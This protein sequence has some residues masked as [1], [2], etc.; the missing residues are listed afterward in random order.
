MLEQ[1]MFDYSPLTLETWEK[2]DTSLDSLGWCV[3]KHRPRGNIDENGHMVSDPDEII[4]G[5]YVD[6]I[7]FQPWWPVCDR[8][9]AENPGAN[10]WLRTYEA[11]FFNDG[12]GHGTQIDTSKPIN[13]RGSSSGGNLKAFILATQTENE[14]EILAFDYLHPEYADGRDFSTDPHL[15][16]YPTA[17]NIA[18]QISRVANG[19]DV[20]V[21]Q[22][23][24][25][26]G[27]WIKKTEVTM[28]DQKPSIWT[29]EDV[30]KQW[31]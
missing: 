24:H 15:F 9:N 26:S 18:G 17:I 8:I 7:P 13:I 10:E 29:K 6:M 4:F 22:I 3:L 2:R 14:I 30:M 27:L 5:D 16:T 28:L 20:F 23:C 25:P 1:V 12:V 11:M 31:M 19:I 21:P